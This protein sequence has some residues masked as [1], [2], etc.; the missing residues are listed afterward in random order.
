MMIELSD[1]EA[2]IFRALAEAHALDIKRGSVTIHFDAE[3]R[4]AQVE[5]VRFTKLSTGNN[6][7]RFDEELKI[8][9]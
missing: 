4:A 9:V 3:G 1:I 5:V 7:T 8:V 2:H 6:P